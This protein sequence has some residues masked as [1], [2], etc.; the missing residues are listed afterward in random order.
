M[1]MLH[2]G[3]LDKFRYYISYKSSK[4]NKMQKK[5]WLK[6]KMTIVIKIN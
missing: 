5:K 2:L 3:N 1:T 6:I 4:K